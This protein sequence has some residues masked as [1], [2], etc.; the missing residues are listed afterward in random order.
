M[1]QKVVKCF[2]IPLPWC[3]YIFWLIHFKWKTIW[4]LINKNFGYDHSQ[5]LSNLKK[6]IYPRPVHCYLHIET[7]QFHFYANQLADF[8]MRK[9]L[10]WYG[11][12]WCL[13]CVKSVRIRTVSSPLFLAFGL[14]IERYGLSLRI[15]SKC[16]K[17]PIIK[18]S[19]TDTFHALLVKAERS[20]LHFNANQFFLSEFSFT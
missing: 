18:T 2:I 7:I 16:V 4:I 19:N 9:T 8:Y 3:S 12:N 14:N 15:Q 17:K 10:G 5:I 1:Q 13:H 20:L 11:L 6:Q